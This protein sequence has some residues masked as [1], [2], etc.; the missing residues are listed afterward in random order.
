MTKPTIEETA[1]GLVRLALEMRAP[2][3]LGVAL[4]SLPFMRGAPAGD[5]HPVLVFPG[6]AA[7][8]MTTAVMRRFLQGQGYQAYAWEQGLNFGPRPGVLEACVE[9]VKQLRAEHGCRVSLVGWSLGGVYAREIAKMLPKDVRLVITLGSPF[10][11]NPKATNAW[12]VYRLVSGEK[13]IDQAR[14]DALRVAPKVPTTSIF[15]RSDGV[16]AWQCSVEQE[17][18]KSENIEVQASHVGMGMNPTAL[19][20]I[21]DRLA[22]PEGKWKRFDHTAHTGL[23]KLLFLDPG[24]ASWPNPFFGFY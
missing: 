15:S 23:K 1:P 10:T 4:A 17:T 11:G 20:A 9:R 24:R 7:G 14:F 16:V 2:W 22:Q 3:E 19:Y 12:R 18:A 6:L 13:E 8:D 21:A 5:G